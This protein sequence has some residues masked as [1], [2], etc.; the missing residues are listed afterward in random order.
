MI[1]AT[2]PEAVKRKLWRVHYTWRIHDIHTHA[3]L[4]AYALIWENTT[5]QFITNSSSKRMFTSNIDY[6]K[7]GQQEKMMLKS[8]KFKV[9]YIRIAVLQ[10]THNQHINCIR[11]LKLH[12]SGQQSSANSSSNRW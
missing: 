7:K 5:H 10:L 3:H 1:A 2:L 9:C 11:C 4:Y 6:N 12:I 8:G